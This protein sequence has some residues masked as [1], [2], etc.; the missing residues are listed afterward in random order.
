[1]AQRGAGRASDGD[2]G[3]KL[4][5][6]SNAARLLD[7]KKATLYTYVSR[8]LITRVRS[9]TSQTSAYLK[10]DVLR[11]KRQ[12][13]ARAGHRAAATTA[14]AWGQPV[15][16]SRIT[17]VRNDKLRFRG[18]DAPEL[19]EGCSFEQVA[20]LLW[21]GK[22]PE[23][24]PQWPRPAS[25]RAVSARPE[26]PVRC[27]QTVLL[28]DVAGTEGDVLE[29]ARQILLRLA[30][31]WPPKV[32]GRASSRRD[33]DLAAL[34][35]DRFEL[36]RTSGRAA[37][38]LALILSADHELN[39][40]TFAARVAASTGAEL[41]QCLLSALATFGGPRHG[42]HS[43]RVE[44]L[45]DELET[46][47]RG[48]AHVVRR[49]LDQDRLLPGFGH[50]LYPKGDPR[51]ALLIDR[52]RELAGRDQR[53]LV[54]ALLK[55]TRNTDHPPPNL[56]FGLVALRRALGLPH[57]SASFLFALGRVAG[58]VAHV[59]EQRTQPGI[60][61]PRARYTGC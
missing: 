19:A 36:S 14:L 55:V 43:E 28:A 24:R 53:R 6:A 5:S 39:A 10:S 46:T 33:T 13:E 41:S 20:E 8:G 38:D 17:D 44:A 56:D 49:R 4:I 30:W 9:D 18:H 26:H 22:L 48:P 51:A 16:D 32:A 25:R 40:S 45:W 42:T 1:M 31:S 21:T 27:F 15:I 61:R 37:I 47:R 58:W 12:H 11:L 29:R 60:L 52:A 59:L 2:G 3:E 57:G 7:I 50:P 34:L 54:N 23:Y 35:S